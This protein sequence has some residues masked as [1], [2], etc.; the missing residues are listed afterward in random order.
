MGIVAVIAGKKKSEKLFLVKIVFTL[1][2]TQI[3]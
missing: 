2:I 3:Q 1:E